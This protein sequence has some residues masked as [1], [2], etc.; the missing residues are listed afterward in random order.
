MVLMVSFQPSVCD[1]F[2]IL[3][4]WRLRQCGREQKY[5]SI[6][7]PE[8]I[9]WMFILWES[10]FKRNTNICY[11]ISVVLPLSSEALPTSL[12]W[13]QSGT[14]GKKSKSCF[15]TV[16][17]ILF[18]YFWYFCTLTFF[19]FSSFTFSGR[20]ITCKTYGEEQV[21]VGDFSL[22][23]SS[24][25]YLTCGIRSFIRVFFSFI[26]I[27]FQNLSCFWL[28]DKKK[29]GNGINVRLN[30]LGWSSVIFVSSSK[31]H[32]GNGIASLV[33]FLKISSEN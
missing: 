33:M 2:P 24:P 29:V 32:H 16:F 12:F 14:G 4:K 19:F 27:R 20:K 1:S 10:D 18:T 15:F 31:G 6:S 28:L 7:N 30:I 9:Q 22:H 3:S 5:F 26:F 17:L 21:G 13:I 8:R 23:V 11:I 25:W